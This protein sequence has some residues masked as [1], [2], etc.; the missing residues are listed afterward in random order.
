MPDRAVAAASTFEDAARPIFQPTLLG[1]DRALLKQRIADSLLSSGGTD[2]EVAFAEAKRQL[3]AMPAAVDR[4]AVVFLSD[5]EPNGPYIADAVIAGAGVP[6]FAIGFGE[7]PG[8][9]LAGIAARSG[10][11]A[12]VVR[13]LARLRRSSRASSRSSRATR[14]S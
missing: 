4:K 3:D 8:E 12:F 5:G 10:A 6:I 14:P 11:Q 9:A 2:Y 7:A 1:S 13:S